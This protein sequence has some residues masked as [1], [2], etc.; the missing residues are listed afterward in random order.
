[1]NQV[2]KPTFIESSK[3]LLLKIL[4]SS[5]L[6]K[7]QCG[8]YLG[9]HKHSLDSYLYKFSGT[10]FPASFAYFFLNSAASNRPL[11]DYILDSK[12]KSK[13]YARFEDLR[14]NRFGFYKMLE[15]YKN[16]DIDQKLIIPALEHHCTILIRLSNSRFIHDEKNYLEQYIDEVLPGVREYLEEYDTWQPDENDSVNTIMSRSVDEAIKATNSKILIDSIKNFFPHLEVL[17]KKY[18]PNFIGPNETFKL[19]VVNSDEQILFSKDFVKRN[20]NLNK[21]NDLVLMN[22]AEDNMQGTINVGDLALII[23]FQN[24]KIKDVIFKNGIYAINLNGNICIRRLQ[25]LN[26]KQRTLVHIISDNK[27]YRD[28]PIDF[29]ELLPLIYG[30]V[31]WRSNNFQDIDFIKHENKEPNLFLPEEDIEI[32]MLL[33]NNKKETA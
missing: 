14:K 15:K 33:N 26:L 10:V 3:D 2:N 8:L 4:K 19:P 28:D 31:V 27:K 25:F 22:V 20:L 7:A 21:Y 11:S 17:R 13:K 16:L 30:E 29:L 32:P 24:K 23:K 12:K 5:Q 18:M 9:K 6:T 1:M